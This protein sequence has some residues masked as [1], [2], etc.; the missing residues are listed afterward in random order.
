MYNQSTKNA[1]SPYFSAVKINHHQI[2][3]FNRLVTIKKNRSEALLKFKKPVILTEH[4]GL[5]LLVM[6]DDPDNKDSFQYFLLQNAIQINAGIYFNTLSLT[7]ECKLYLEPSQNEEPQIISLKEK[8]QVEKDTARIKIDDVFGLHYQVYSSGERILNHPQNYYEL[9]IVDQGQA[10]MELS[11]NNQPLLT[12]NS[13]WLNFPGQ[14]N[15]IAFKEDGMTTLISILFTGQ[16]LSETIAQRPINL[17]HRQIQLVSRLV[18]LANV[19]EEKYPFSYDEIVTSLQ[20][21]ITQMH[22]GEDKITTEAS[23]SMRENYENDLFQSIVDFLQENV[24][25]QH[26]VNDLVDKFN[27]SRSSLQTL[28]N[29]YTGQTP[30]QYI[31]SLRLKQSKLLIHESKMTLSEIA[32]ELGYG[33]IQYFSRAFSNEFGISPSNFAKSILK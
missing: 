20:L 15:Q 30:K 2:K 28:F 10:S 6:T 16:G 18:N 1:M 17:G 4:K 32:N 24:G 33:S 9:I 7:S 11:Y 12:K 14:K 8:I 5:A 21:I 27:I 29:K 22:N 13:A 31:N 19:T 3:P 26:Q 23:T 25:Q